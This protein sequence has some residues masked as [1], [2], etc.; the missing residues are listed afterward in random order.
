MS[1]SVSGT[2]RLTG[3]TLTFDAGTSNAFE[4]CECTRYTLTH[5][6]YEEKVVE[7][8]GTASTV[9][10]P[11]GESMELVCDVV[12][13][14]D[15]AGPPYATLPSA[16]VAVDISGGHD[17]TVGGFTHVL[18][19]SHSGGDWCYMGGNFTAIMDDAATGQMTFRKWKGITLTKPT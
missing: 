13:K 1:V 17:I 7:I 11:S 5:A 15:A 16:G 6:P 18:N 19:S 3:S 10:T 4:G 14:S 9:I 8:A 2:S 12:T